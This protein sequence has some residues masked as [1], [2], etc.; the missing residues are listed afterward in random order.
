MTGQMLGIYTSVQ[1]LRGEVYKITR[2]IERIYIHDLCPKV[3]MSHIVGL[4]S[5]G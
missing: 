3:E 1:R 2:D 4:R 5:L